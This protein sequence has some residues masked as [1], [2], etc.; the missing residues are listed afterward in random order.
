MADAAILREDDRVEL[1]EG[2]IIDMTPIGSRHASVLNRLNEIM[3]AP[4]RG[5]AIVSVQNPIVLDE[6]SEP[7]P[8]LMLLE[9]REDYYAD[10][11]PRPRDVLLLVEVA[12]SSADYDRRVKIP[13]YATSGVAEVWLIDLQGE[14][15]EVYREPGAHGYKHVLRPDPDEPVRPERLTGLAIALGDIAPP[16]I[17]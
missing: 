16:S 2:E 7:Q 13:L 10:R 17:A 4:A 5:K 12:D 6:H 14:A 9:P 8:D 11:H 3:T 15:L 1:I